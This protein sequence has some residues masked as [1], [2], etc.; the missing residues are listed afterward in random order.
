[1][2][3]FRRMLLRN[4]KASSTRRS[5]GQ[6][7]GGVKED[8]WGNV[9]HLACGGSMVVARSHAILA[10]MTT[11]RLP[12]TTADVHDP[13]A[14]PYFLWWTDVTV[15]QLRI[16]LRSAD[17]EERAYW[18]G[19]LLREANT[20]DV[21]VFVTPSEVR[22]LWPQLVRHLGKTR[23]MWAWLLGVEDMPWPPEAALHA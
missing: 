21:W 17:R 5:T 18:L 13:D 16:L 22:G 20:R 4:S 10:P 9:P 23:S 6:G 14:R 3:A 19:A 1:M 8:G 12:P 7:C 2:P 15:A 11:L